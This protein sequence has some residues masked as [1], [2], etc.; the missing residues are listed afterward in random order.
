MNHL[1]V[2]KFGECKS[3]GGSF[4]FIDRDLPPKCCQTLKNMSSFIIMETIRSLT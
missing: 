2:K 1:C 3:E 4:A